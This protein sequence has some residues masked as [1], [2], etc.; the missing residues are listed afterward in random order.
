MSLAVIGKL[1]GEDTAE[2]IATWAEYEWHRDASWD[3]FR[4]KVRPDHAIRQVPS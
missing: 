4:K 3:P 2:Q 1:L